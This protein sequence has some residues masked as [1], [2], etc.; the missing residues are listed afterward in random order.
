MTVIHFWN[1]DIRDNAEGVVQ[2]ILGRAAECLGDTHPQPSRWDPPTMP[3]MVPH[4]LF[5]GGKGKD[6]GGMNR[7]E[8]STQGCGAAGRVGPSVRLES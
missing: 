7:G 2:A 5:Q 6:G 1:S 4:L 8:A 3:G